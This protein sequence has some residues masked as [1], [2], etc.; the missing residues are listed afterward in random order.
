MLFSVLLQ[1]KSSWLL[2]SSSVFAFGVLWFLFFCSP[3]QD[4]NFWFFW[5]EI[6]LLLDE[7]QVF[8]R[9]FLFCFC[10]WWWS[11]ELAAAHC[12][13]VIVSY[14]V[15]SSW[16]YV[17]VEQ[18]RTWLLY[19]SVAKFQQFRSDFPFFQVLL[20]SILPCY[21]VQLH[22]LQL[23]VVCFTELFGLS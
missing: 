4:W 6:K 3:C 7:T 12:K 8:G 15:T 13:F 10:F 22:L 14:R 20:S 19:S 9:S 17:K 2:G 23:G 5:S 11:L 18:V 16:D 1:F 21:E